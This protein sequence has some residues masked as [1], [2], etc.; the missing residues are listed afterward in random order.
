MTVK[1]ALAQFASEDGV[2]ANVDKMEAAIREAAAN[3]AKLIAFHELATTHYFCFVERD[4][5]WL[6]LAEPVPG[7]TTDRIGALVEELGISVL[8]PVYE[9]EDGIQYNTAVLIEPGVG[10]VGKYQKSHVPASKARGKQGGAEE[11]WYFKPGKT[12]FVAWD[13]VTGLKIGTLICYDRHHPEGQR[14][15]GKL[16]IDLLFVP[17]ASYRAF[18]TG[19]IWEAEL[20]SAAF[21]NSYYVAGIN[22]VGKVPFIEA[23]ANFPGRSIFIDPEGVILEKADD[24]E[25]IIYAD[26]DTDRLAEVRAP[27]NFFEFRRP[28]LYG[29]LTQ[30]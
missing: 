18:V 4:P 12:G 13:S 14:A 21:Q 1:V 23:D 15:Y 10:I 16:G 29:S 3:G 24:Q 5:S 22:K 17:T 30:P 27:L 25:G 28:D 2:E 26:I 20:M 9:L 7:P 19:P 6:E 8:A 11:N